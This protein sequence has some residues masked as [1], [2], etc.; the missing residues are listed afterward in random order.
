M[1]LNGRLQ[2]GAPYNVTTG[3]DDN[4]DA[5]YND[6]PPGVARNSLRGA[7]TTQTNFRLSWTVPVQT[8]RG[9]VRFQ[10]GPRSPGG[11]GGRLGDGN[12]PPQRRFEMFLFVSNLL[13]R[14]NRS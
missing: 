1:S 9:A 2:S 5:F 10:R 7:Y 14:G 12:R 8:P 11:P 3:F 4:G 13:N 6:R